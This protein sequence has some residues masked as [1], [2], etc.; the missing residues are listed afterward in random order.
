MNTVPGIGKG[1]VIRSSRTGPD[2]ARIITDY[3]GDEQCQHPRPRLAQKPAALHLRE[4]LADGVEGLNVGAA[5]EQESR[6]GDLVLQA[7]P[8]PA[9]TPSGSTRL[10]SSG[11]GRHRCHAF[12]GIDDPT[13]RLFAARVGQ[14]MSRLAHANRA[15]RHA[16][17]IGDDY[18]AAQI[19]RSQDRL[20][21][22]RHARGRFAG[23]DDKRGRV[24]VLRSGVAGKVVRNQFGGIDGTDR[25]REKSRPPPRATAPMPR[26]SNRPVGPA[27][28]RH[29]G[30]PGRTREE[31]T[32]TCSLRRCRSR[33]A[34][35]T[36]V[37]LRS[38]V[39]PWLPFRVPPGN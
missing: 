37:R 11:K 2:R 19:G 5:L 16:A 15:Q 36:P 34:C 17:T 26:S 12:G 30:L 22:G 35:G 33:S 18:F 39:L 24:H 29:A 7:S 8:E 25:R 10:H 4:M 28:R 13:R 6:R 21:A 27:A 23:A 3:V 14:R 9:G 20:A 1:G 31:A 38:A 32:S